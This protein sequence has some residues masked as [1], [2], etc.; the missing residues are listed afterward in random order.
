LPGITYNTIMKKKIVLDTNVLI[1]ALRS[2]KGASFQ[3]LKRIGRGQFD[4][5]LSVPLFLEYEDVAKR[6]SRAV[7]LR[8]SDIDDILDYLC[9]VGE[10]REIFFLWRPFLK[11][12]MDD[13][14]LEVAVESNCD[15]IVTHNIKDFRGIEKFGIEAIRPG[16]FLRKLVN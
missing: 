5:V 2:R 8:H 10:H 4:I 13:M 6:T 3:V 16:K 15:Y 9:S 7:G 12:P 11:D 14:V 1:A